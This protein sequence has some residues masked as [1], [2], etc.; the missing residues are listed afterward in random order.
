MVRWSVLVASA[1]IVVGAAI[2]TRA[3]VSSPPV[4]SML[5]PDVVRPTGV[6][7][8]KIGFFNMALVMREYKRAQNAVQRLT[9]RKDR[10]T[11]NLI[12]MREM[13]KSLHEMPKPSDPDLL[14]QATR[15]RVMLAR[16]IEDLDR[17]I[18][19][20]LNNQASMIIS[21]LYDEIHN[22]TIDMARERGLSV[23]FAYPDA[24][25]PQDRENPLV[26]ELKL[27][28]P[29][30]QPFFLDPSADYSNELVE[31]LNSKFASEHDGD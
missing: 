6:S 17:E 2:V 16:Q 7:S 22:M 8:Q 4:D 23:I 29:A 3:S 10:M 26:K 11:K 5:K 1:A 9:A 15:E 18:N 12:G 31:R 25:S 20:L 30:A 19:K 13:F 21:E 27:K 14:E 28:P 24:V